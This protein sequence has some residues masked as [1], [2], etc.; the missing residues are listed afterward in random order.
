M[1]TKERLAELK[2]IPYHVLA[3]PPMVDDLL[4]EIGDLL[5]ENEEM[6]KVL[7]EIGDDAGKDLD[8]LGALMRVAEAAEQLIE[9]PDMLS[10]PQRDVYGS[11]IKED[12]EAPLWTECGLYGRVGKDA[13]R[14]LLAL[15]RKLRESLQALR[16]VK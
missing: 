3:T 15:H 6:K 5:R 16:E 12:R 10:Y 14:T 1:I 9:E 13:A 11:C 7:E 8:E 2:Q 4:R